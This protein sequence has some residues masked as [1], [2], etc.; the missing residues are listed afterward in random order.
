MSS[1]HSRG[2]KRLWKAE[3]AE[4]RHTSCSQGGPDEP[5]QNPGA[6]DVAQGFSEGRMEGPI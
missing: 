5:E 1:K 3:G 2:Q 4:Q 6:E